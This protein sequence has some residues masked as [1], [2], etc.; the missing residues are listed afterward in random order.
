MYPET[1]TGVDNFQEAPK[2]FVL[3]Q[4]YPNPFNPV[5]TIKYSIPNVEE[6]NYSLV[7]LKVYNLLGQ[8]VATLV[9]EQQAPGIYESEFDGSNLASGIYI[10]KLQAGS[11]VSTKKLMLMK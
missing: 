9:S 1:I 3:E 5:T 7:Q 11:F 6:N 8:E 10:Y 4:N 2:G